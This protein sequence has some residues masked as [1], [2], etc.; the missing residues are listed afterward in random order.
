[1]LYLLDQLG[2]RFTPFVCFEGF[3]SNQGKAREF[4]ILQALGRQ[5]KGKLLT[6]LDPGHEVKKPWA[7]PTGIMQPWAISPSYESS[8]PIA[9]RTTQDLDDDNI[10]VAAVQLRIRAQDS[11]PE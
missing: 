10:Q 7:Y 2:V 3:T 1:M 4:L 6:N 5:G 11:N 8:W 9:R